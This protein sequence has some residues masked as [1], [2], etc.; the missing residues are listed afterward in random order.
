MKSHPEVAI[1]PA[2]ANNATT[3]NVCEPNGGQSQVSHPIPPIMDRM[4]R[5]R[6]RNPELKISQPRNTVSNQKKTSAMPAPWLLILM[7]AS[8]SASSCVG[9]NAETYDGFPSRR[10]GA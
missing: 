2:M 4:P 10:S 1:T 8:A 5:K 7:N 3:V 6:G 9:G